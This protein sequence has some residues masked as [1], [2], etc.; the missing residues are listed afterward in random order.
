MADIRLSGPP[1]R[2][3]RPVVGAGG[4]LAAFLLYRRRYARA[5]HTPRLWSTAAAC[6]CNQRRTRQSDTRHHKRRVLRM[7]HI[8]MHHAPPNFPLIASATCSHVR[9]FIPSRCG[10][11]SSVWGF[12]SH[13]VGLAQCQLKRQSPAQFRGRLIIP[14]HH[15]V[16]IS[17]ARRT[18]TQA[19][20]GITK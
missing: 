7:H 14:R 8:G 1:Q 20:S 15:F 5:Q 11:G 10:K 17:A 18:S 12:W 2:P 16:A 6:R 19:A 4:T 13:T 3:L 9:S